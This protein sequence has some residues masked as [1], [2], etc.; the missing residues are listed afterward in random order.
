MDCAL[1]VV[2]HEEIA[3]SEPPDPAT[4]GLDLPASREGRVCRLVSRELQ[5]QPDR[6][7][8]PPRRTKSGPSIRANADGLP[9]PRRACDLRV[10]PA[11]FQGENAPSRRACF[12]LL[13]LVRAPNGSPKETEGYRHAP[14]NEP[15]QRGHRSGIS[16]LTKR[17]PPPGD[18]MNRVIFIIPVP[19]GPQR[20]RIGCLS[21][22]PA[23]RRLPLR[24]ASFFSCRPITRGEVPRVLISRLPILRP[25]A[26]VAVRSQHDE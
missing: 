4:G 2:G 19:D 9:G 12:A 7:G 20:P 10:A 26:L 11:D 17:E 3:L 23:A 6:T 21:N 14:R 5:P 15:A 16:S 25:A 22:S 18:L 8:P 1:G 13:R 24:V